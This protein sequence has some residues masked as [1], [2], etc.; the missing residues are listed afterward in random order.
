MVSFDLAE[1]AQKMRS[2]HPEWSDRQC[3]CCLYWQGT[4]NKSL[5]DAIAEFQETYPD[6]IFTLKPEAMGVNVFKTVRRFGV[7]IKARP[8]DIIFKIALVGYPKN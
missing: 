2:R 7:P 6:V 1:F 5:K 3:R 8:K 4:V